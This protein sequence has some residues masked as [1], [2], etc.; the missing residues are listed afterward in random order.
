MYAFREL[1]VGQD[2]HQK[3]FDQKLFQEHGVDET[4]FPT[5]TGVVREEVHQKGQ[6]YGSQT[7]LLVGYSSPPCCAKGSFEKMS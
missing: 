2:K 5:P 7:L 3:P 6:P 4:N 1:H